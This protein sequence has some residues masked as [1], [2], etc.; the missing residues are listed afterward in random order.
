MVI[1]GLFRHFASW[2]SL[3]NSGRATLE[4]LGQPWVGNYGKAWAAMDGKLWES[5]GNH[6]WETLGKLG[7]P[8]SPLES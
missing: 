7:Q 6:G 5:L 8:W 4:K 3:G 1:T 2:E